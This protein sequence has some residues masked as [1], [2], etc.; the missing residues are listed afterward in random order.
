MMSPKS[1]YKGAN[2]RAAKTVK[3][4]G[5]DQ[6]KVHWTPVFARGKVSIYI[7]DADAARRDRKLPA[8]LNDGAELAKFVALFRMLSARFSSCCFST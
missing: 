3:S 8:R 7:C 2:L 1:K 4:Q 6:D 5:C